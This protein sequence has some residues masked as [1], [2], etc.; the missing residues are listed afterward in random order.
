MFYIFKILSS[1]CIFL[2]VLY[3]Y[4]IYGELELLTLYI[5][6]AHNRNTFQNY[7]QLS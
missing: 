1:M 3:L 4:V 5:G 2:T 7:V 6:E